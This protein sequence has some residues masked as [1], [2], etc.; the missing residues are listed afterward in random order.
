MRSSTDPTY[1]NIVSQ[2]DGPLRPLHTM[3]VNPNGT[4]KKL[5][6][7]DLPVIQG[8][9]VDV[10]QFTGSKKALCCNQY[11]KCM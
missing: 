5:G 8:E 7:K 2:Y 9:I 6:G 3:M 10:I 1:T 4:I 11:G